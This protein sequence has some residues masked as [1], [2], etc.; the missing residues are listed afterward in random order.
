MELRKILE[1][2]LRRKWI[3]IQAF[4]VVFLT[5][6]IGSYFI[7]PV[8][9]TSSKLLLQAPTITASVLSDLGMKEIAGFLPSRPAELYIGTKVTLAKVNP[10]LEKVI[11][12]LQ[13]RDDKGELFI[14]EKLLNISLL[15]RLFP[16][17]FVSVEQDPDSNTIAITARSSDPNEAMFI[18]NTLSEMYIEDNENDRKKET[19]SARSFIEIQMVKAKDDYSS[20][21][22]DIIAF[23][24]RNN[25]VNLEIETRIAI[26]KMAE[27]MKQKEDNVINISETQTKIETLKNQMKQT[28]PS[29]PTL[30]MKDNPQI[31]RI[32][33]DLSQT[34]T[35]LAG[36]LTDKTENHPDVFSLRQQIKELEKDLEKEV[37]VH[38]T[39]SPELNEFERQLAALNV[40]LEGINKDI[41]KYVSLIKTIPAK[42]SEE[43]KLKLSLTASQEIY[44]SLLDY[45]NRIGVAEAMVFPDATLVQPAMKPYEPESPKMILNGI[46]GA[47]LGLFFALGLAFFAEYVDDTLKTP[48]ELEQYKEFTFLGSI[49]RIRKIKLIDGLDVNDP[50]SE[51]YRTIRYSIKYASLDKPVKSFLVTSSGPGEGKT[52]TAANLGISFSQAG[53]RVLL[54]DTDLRRP[55]LHELFKKSNQIGLTNVVAIEREVEEAIT[56]TGIKGLS[57]L[58]SGPVPID[59]G[60]MFESERLKEL[61][62]TVTNSYD[63]VIL[64]SAPLLIKSDATVLGRRVD[65]VI[66]VLEAGETNRK[67]IAKMIEILKK[68][69]V[70]LLGVVLNKY[71]KGKPSYHS[72][73]M[74][75][76]KKIG[77]R[78]SKVT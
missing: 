24:Q 60:R 5:V 19:Q 55:G 11:Y 61:I 51:A 34:R 21:L 12:R 37:Q 71:E 6:L 20:S 38:Q 9:E 14:P 22:R 67:A 65:G 39:T 36:E 54:V 63:V 7:T 48:E 47:F 53:A 13:I 23:Q 49:P 42:N 77:L 40:H 64:D 76:L 30:I 33:Q 1:I 75:L 57:L 8:Y 41:N 43:A 74:R 26:E 31:Q 18:A 15:S 50:I 28:S 45:G 29:V 58:P 46:L 3:A 59:P 78:K 35:K 10:L 44:S 56:D 69:S 66:F 25:T 32:M 16:A 27:L 52:L 2:I 73:K 62:G 70:R 17:P 68:T 4:L 72:P